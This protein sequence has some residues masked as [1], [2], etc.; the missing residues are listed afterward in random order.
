MAEPV[1][2]HH[3]HRRRPLVREHRA[4]HVRA[5][6][7]GLLVLLL[8]LVGAPGP[9]S[10]V[11]VPDPGPSLRGAF[12]VPGPQGPVLGSP[13]RRP[14]R[15]G[16]AAHRAWPVEP[17]VVVAE[18]DL[19]EPDWLPGHRGLD[20]QAVPGQVVRSAADGV[21]TFAGQVGGRGVVVVATG[22]WRASYEPVA[23]HVAVGEPVEAAQPLGVLAPSGGHC[24][25]PA[26][27]LHWGLRA[28]EHYLDPR[29]L[30]EPP[31]PVLLPVLSR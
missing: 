11:V 4:G 3:H 27:C 23:A 14:A 7:A 25:A 12:A 29:W 22:G 24:G 26:S 18:I 17:A 13:P 28:G 30:L 5:L 20:L 15:P 16:P 6:L 9:A 1:P 31:V 2:H 10:G 8:G 19:P 21:V